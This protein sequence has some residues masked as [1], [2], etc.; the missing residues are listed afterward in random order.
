[1]TFFHVQAWPL[2]IMDELLQDFASW[3]TKEEELQERID[4]LRE[5]IE[6]ASPLISVVTIVEVKRSSYPTQTVYIARRP[7]RPRRKSKKILCL[8]CGQ[9]PHVPDACK[10][11]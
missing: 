6:A 7:C 4:Q 8:S 2:F 10:P 9:P 11:S 3:T 5:R 1:M